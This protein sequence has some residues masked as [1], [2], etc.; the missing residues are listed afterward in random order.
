MSLWNGDSQ[1]APAQIAAS[2]ETVT[3]TL[4]TV[5]DGF[6]PGRYTLTAKYA[7]TGDMAAQTA[8]VSFTVAYAKTQEGAEVSGKRAENGA[9][10]EQSSLIAPEDA[11]IALRNGADAEWADSLVLPAEDG[12]H[13]Y[14]YYLKLKDGTIAEKTV[15]VTVDTASPV[16]QAPTV[17]ADPTTAEISAPATDAVSGVKDYTLTVNSG[18]NKEAVVITDHG[19][20]SYTVTGLTPG[21][22]YDFTLV[23]TD[24]A[25][26][27]IEVSF[28]VTAPL[29]PSLPQTGDSS[30]LAL[31]L[32]L[33]GTALAGMIILRR[34]A[35]N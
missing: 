28:S 31:W 23:V 25:G 3:F 29:A 34:K 1:L 33:M 26:H 6:T 35:H 13:T 11:Q 8:E 19:D 15:T 18:E 16:L 30:R 2:G 10:T 5:A 21:E 24:L 12:T 22:T 9:Y 7:A 32:M 20:G 4:S 27:A 17:L 14:I